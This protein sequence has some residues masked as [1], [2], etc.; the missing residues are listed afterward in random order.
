[1][2]RHTPPILAFAVM[3]LVL[4]AAVAQAQAIRTDAGFNTNALAAND[5]ESTGL[6]G[7]GFTIDFFGS[8]YS[9]L[10]VNNNGNVTFD[11]ELA[12]FTPF[13]LLTTGRVIMAPFFAD[14]DTRGAGSDIVR[15]GTS[16]I[17]GRLAF[18]VNF[19]NVGYFP[20]SFDK[21]NTFQL[22]IIDRSDIAA[23][24][25]DFEFNYSQ[26]QWETGGASG[27]VDGLGG[28]SARVGWSNGDDM[29][30]ELP[31]SAVNGAFLD[32][33]PNALISNSLNSQIDGR[34]VFEVRQ[35]Q[36][37]PPPPVTVPEPVSLL[38]LG[39]GLLGVAAVQRRRRSIL[40][41]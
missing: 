21:L 2:R 36:V 10:Y 16:T 25:F 37:V 3:A 19:F 22:V 38:L 24:D 23:G 14:V 7:L 35:G 6:V 30:F 13:D 11:E 41:S 1:M 4:T 39:T 8:E 12:T 29:A 15:Y 9:Q 40:E 34:Y 31:G 28:N 17:D 26:I 18:G 27:G 5:D 20:S 33:G 32:G